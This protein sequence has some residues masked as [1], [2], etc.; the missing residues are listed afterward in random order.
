MTP[1]EFISKDS[2]LMII[3]LTLILGSLLLSILDQNYRPTFA[4]LAK[5]SITGVLGWLAPSPTS[6]GQK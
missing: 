2:F 3:V 6:G 1:R 4:D 5:L